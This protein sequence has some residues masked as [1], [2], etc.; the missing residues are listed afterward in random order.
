S[1]TRPKRPSPYRLLQPHTFLASFAPLHVQGWRLDMITTS[2]QEFEDHSR[3]VD[4]Q[5]RRLVRIY[6]FPPE[7]EGWVGL[8]RFFTKISDIIQEENHHPGIIISPSTD[9]N[10]SSTALETPSRSQKTY[11][12]EITTYTHTPMPPKLG[13]ENNEQGIIRPGVT[14]K[15]IRL[16]ER[17]EEVF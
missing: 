10:P 13:T 6:D 2:T 3:G 11:I 1:T 14:G 17:F 16:A 15:D 5:D 12:L 4:L 8:S 7:R 9:Y